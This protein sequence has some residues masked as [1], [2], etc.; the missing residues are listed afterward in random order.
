MVREKVEK[1]KRGKGLGWR[2]QMA[3]KRLFD[4]TLSAFLLFTFSPLFFI[5]SFLTRLTMSPPIFFRQPRLG[6][7]GRPFVIYKFR[8]MI[9]QQDEQGN[10]LPDEQRLTQLGRFLRSTTLDEL[11][12][13]INVLR[14]EMSLVGP[15]P[16]LVDYRDLYTPEQWRRHEMLPGM[17]G[18]VLA[19]GRNILSWDEKFA[20]D[21]WYVDNW[22]LWLDFQILALTALK[23]L[24]RE[25][26]S[27]E[28]YATMPRFEGTSVNVH[29][30]RNQMWQEEQMPSEQSFATEAVPCGLCGAD[31]FATL[32]SEKVLGQLDVA[33]VRCAQCGFI[34]T[35]PRPTPETLAYIYSK[36]HYETKGAS[37]TYCLEGD[38]T[39]G[40]FKHGLEIIAQYKSGGRLLDVGCGAGFF[41]EQAM[42]KGVW[43][44]FGVDLSAYA[45]ALARQRAGCPVHTGTLETAGFLSLWFDVIT[46][47]CLLEHVPDPKAVLRESR[48]LLKEDGILLV[49]V[50][51]VNYLLLRNRAAKF[52]GKSS[53]LHPEE[54][55]S[56]FSQ[57]TLHEMLTQEGF[58]VVTERVM[59]PF[60]IGGILSTL[61]K[62]ASFTVAQLLLQLTGVNY[63]GL[64]VL[65]RPK[66]AVTPS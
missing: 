23:V 59:R 58:E 61:V 64:L 6:H 28:G 7:Q 12:E 30:E 45:S 29:H 65:A 5:I 10:Q 3:I 38:V 25:G 2:S 32:V 54:H 16:L 34:Y 33:I 62:T 13:L 43:Q 21:V 9:D 52:M 42:H 56:H 20:L 37:G 24:K 44:C 11:P 35:N 18:P 39:E 4:I 1:G 27:A 8:T 26:V 36:A 66:A 15:R 31:N 46:L 57:R 22:S 40:Q 53:S 17:A 50:P 63:G 60:L 14:G 47:W 48:T 41:L 19:G 55:L 49:A 51:N